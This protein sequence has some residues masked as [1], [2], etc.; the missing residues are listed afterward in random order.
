MMTRIVSAAFI[1]TFGVWVFTGSSPDG[2]MR[3]LLLGGLLFVVW[4]GHALE[5][6]GGFWEKLADEYEAR[7]ISLRRPATPKPQEKVVVATTE[8]NSLMS[9]RSSSGWQGLDLF[10]LLPRQRYASSK[11]NS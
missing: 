10:V 3:L 9:A 1:G 4:L 6:R 11:S 8:I 2:A 7:A 5:S